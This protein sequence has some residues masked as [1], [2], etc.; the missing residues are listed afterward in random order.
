MKLRNL[1]FLTALIFTLFSLGQ[2]GDK[3]ATMFQGNPQHTGVYDTQAAYKLKGVKFIFKT[4][5]PIR[6]T[7]ALSKGILYIGSGDGN[8]YAMDAQSGKNLWQYTTGGAVHSSPAVVDDIVYFTSR[9]RYL[10]ALNAKTGKEIWKF[11][12]GKE[13][14]YQYGFDYYLSSPTIEGKTLYVGGGDGYLYAFDL[15][16]RNV[17]WKFNA[18]SRIRSTPAVAGD[19]VL[20]GTMNGYLHAVQKNNG[21]AKWKFATFG[22]TLNF[23]DWGYDRTAILSSPSVKDGIVTVGSRDG[24]LYA[25]DLATGKERWRFDH[26]IS[27]VIS[28]PAI[29][30]GNVFVGSSDGHFV[31]AVDF[32]TGAEKWRL[33]TPGI[34]WS[35]IAI[36]KNVMYFGEGTGSIY[37]ADSKTGKA[38][39]SYPTG[40]AI[41][42]SP[43][44]SDGIVYCG[45]DNG[46]LY[47]LVGTTAFDTTTIQ[48]KKVVSWQG[49]KEYNWFQNSVDVGV[50]DYFQKAGYELMDAKKLEDFIKQQIALK[51]PSV[52]VF[53]DNKFPKTVISED[54]KLDQSLIRQYL[55]AWGKVVVLGVNPAAY[56][57]DYEKKELNIDFTYP[58][59]IFGIQYPGVYLDALGGVYG[60]RATEDGVKWGI[61]GWW[62]G[63]GSVD[64]S[65]VTTVLGVDENGMA[66]AWVKN[67]GGP[68]GTGLLQLSISRSIPG[69]LSP[70]KA[71]AE[72]GLDW[73]N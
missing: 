35:S 60:S 73:K 40:G 6:G 11:Q 36:A 52:I 5:G 29:N 51:S 61:S 59:R 68:G 39:W 25:V 48:S 69:D 50:R 31:Q 13:V 7:P 1:S 72:F 62:T 2:A 57:Y 26:K 15:G 20:V 41:F 17:K 22:T 66:S 45:T 38:L 65:Q 21:A 4:E 64:R 19:L 55:N 47:A 9:D 58:Q 63:F 8:F 43:I 67:Y 42:A 12:M 54:G 28:T 23:N 37:A 71:A 27:W 33:K 56:L 14:H 24:F 49:T 46:N 10:Y 44:I 30:D 34:V 3:S 18:E 16:T 53:A 70:I 32:A